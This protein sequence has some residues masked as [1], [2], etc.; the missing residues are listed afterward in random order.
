[1]GKLTGASYVFS[2]GHTAGRRG[3][4]LHTV[5]MATI[6]EATYRDNAIPSKIPTTGASM[7]VQW[8]RPC[9]PTAGG[10]GFDPWLG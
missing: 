1:M 8:L 4:E 7:A 6:P 10:T 9:A 5:R 3:A 2:Q